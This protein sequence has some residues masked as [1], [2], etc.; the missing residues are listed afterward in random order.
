MSHQFYGIAFAIIVLLLIC[1]EI[2]YAATF[3]KSVKFDVDLVS[4]YKKFTPKIRDEIE[5]LDSQFK[6]EM[7]SHDGKKWMCVLPQISSSESSDKSSQE[8]DR[9]HAD[10]KTQPVEPLLAPLSHTCIFR[11][12]G[13]WTYE[14]CYGRHVKQFHQERT[15]RITM[16]YNLG[17]AP[18]TTLEDEEPTDE[19]N[20][21]K[22]THY[23][24][25]GYYAVWYRG[26]TACD[27]IG[28]APRETEVRFYC[29]KTGD[30]IVVEIQE[31]ST[32]RYVVRVDTPLICK[33][34]KFQTSEEPP[35]KIIC[36]KITPDTID[37][38]VTDSLSSQQQSVGVS[39]EKFFSEK[40]HTRENE[41][42]E[43]QSQ[44]EGIQQLENVVELLKRIF[45]KRNVDITSDSDESPHEKEK[46]TTTKETDDSEANDEEKDSDMPNL[47]DE[48]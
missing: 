15:G 32:C 26:G 30:T 31:P 36:Y 43:E 48:L 42:G 29:S 46:Q 39:K 7:T 8:N 1:F 13:W 44:S 22:S 33:H 21:E 27:L 40:M 6:M 34:P 12:E 25:N 41:N 18:T 28:N 45:E 5:A 47:R 16:A 9:H 3:G 11:F 38:S 37:L 35:H 10:P 24:G 2:A 17:L 19:S 14:F 4:D 20:T 23:F